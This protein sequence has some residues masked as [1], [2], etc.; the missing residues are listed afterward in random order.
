[1]SALVRDFILFLIDF[2]EPGLLAMA[3]AG[4]SATGLI[5]WLISCLRSRTSTSSLRI[6]K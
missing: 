2:L 4:C 3:V 5:N 6:L 1:M